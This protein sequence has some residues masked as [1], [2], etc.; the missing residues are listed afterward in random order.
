MLLLALTLILT[1]VECNFHLNFF[2]TMKTTIALLFCIVTFG[3]TSSIQCQTA[4][5]A[6]FDSSNAAAALPSNASASVSAQEAARYGD[7]YYYG[8][9]YRH[10]TEINPVIGMSFSSMYNDPPNYSSTSR[11]G[12]LIGFNIRYGN[13]FYFQPG[14]DFMGMNS[15]LQ[16]TSA[17]NVNYQSNQT[18]INVLRIPLLAGFR[19]FRTSS[20]VNLNFHAGISAD[21]VTSI[22]TNNAAVQ[23][24]E[25][26]SPFWGG[27]IGAGLDFA[28]LTFDLDYDYGLSQVFDSGYQPYGSGPRNASVILTFGVRSPF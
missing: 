7:D 28:F 11:V 19:V 13:R 5:P 9:E 10:H 15:Q 8:D 17:I 16:S 1:Q 4:L 3:F 20:P 14:I 18:D 21:F 24:D 25:Y 12:W 27:V 23:G 2:N 6:H 26:N 22:N